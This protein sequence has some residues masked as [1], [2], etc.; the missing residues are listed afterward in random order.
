MFIFE[1]LDK[2]VKCQNSKGI[3]TII[4]ENSLDSFLSNI[5]DIEFYHI[6]PRIKF[7][8]SS[9]NPYVIRSYVGR[10]RVGERVLFFIMDQLEKVKIQLLMLVLDRLLFI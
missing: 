9:G 8:T 6:Q 4:P 3:V 7:L 1:K 2:K 10:D 5:K